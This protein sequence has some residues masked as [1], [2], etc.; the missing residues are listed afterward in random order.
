M[1]D[2]SV[3][4]TWRPWNSGLETYS[5]HYAPE[6]VI[7]WHGFLVISSP[8]PKPLPLLFKKTN[9]SDVRQLK[10]APRRESIARSRH[11]CESGWSR[12]V[13]PAKVFFPEWAS[14]GAVEV[15]IHAK[16]L[17]SHLQKKK[18]SICN[19]SIATSPTVYHINIFGALASRHIPRMEEE[20]RAIRA[21]QL[22]A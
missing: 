11:M 9:G 15:I 16:V 5:S 17:S 2:W 8:G 13:I 7:S 22:V 19:H 4:Y 20:M 1:L 12:Q 14:V 10:G 3:P 21:L 6:N 18:R